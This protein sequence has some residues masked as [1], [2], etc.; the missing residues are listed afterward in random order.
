MS[1][2]DLE[3]LRERF[4]DGYCIYPYICENEEELDSYCDKCPLNE[5]AEVIIKEG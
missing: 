3:A 2:Q 1:Q 5:L 4:C